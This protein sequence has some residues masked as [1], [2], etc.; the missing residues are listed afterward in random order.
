MGMAIGPLHVRR[1]ILINAPAS[2]IW[3]E[4]AS[5]DKIARWF[6]LG[7]QLHTFEPD[8]G[9]A[10][11]MSI[12]GDAGARLHYSGSVLLIEPEREISFATRWHPV[13][14]D[15][16]PTLWT[17]RLTP[18]YEGTHVEIFH[19]GYE[20]FGAGAA[21]ALEGFEGGWD[22]KHL[23]ALRGVVED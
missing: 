9:G 8:V 17:I 5:F 19:H 18:M 22:M 23:R 6:D 16:H 2:R 20:Q 10:V 11:E 1:S 21:D 3:E 4:F 7:H 15:P 12:E 13:A 14:E